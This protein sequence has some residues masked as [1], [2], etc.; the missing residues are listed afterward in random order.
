MSYL[1]LARAWRPQTFDEAVG[2]QHV[3][4]TLKNA[5]R[6]G[7]VAHAYLFSGPRG[8]GKTSLARILAKAVNCEQ[9]PTPDPCGTCTHCVEIRE[10]SAI[11]VQEI[12]GASNRGIEEIRELRENARYLP[13]GSRYKIYI[14]DEVHMLTKEAFNALLKT[15]EE[16]PRHVLFVF[17]TTEAHRVPATIVSRCQKF[18]FRRVPVRELETHLRRIVEHEDVEVDPGGLAILARQADGSVRDALSLLDQVISYGDRKVGVAMVRDILGLVDREFVLSLIENLVFK[19]IVPVLEALENVY[20]GGYDLKQFHHSLL[21]EIRSLML[22]KIGAGGNPEEDPGSEEPLR[23]IL[24]EV[25]VP[26]LQAAQYELLKLD[27][28]LRYASIPRLTLELGLLRLAHLNDF[29]GLSFLLPPEPSRDADPTG[30]TADT[31][32]SPERPRAGYHE[33][34]EANPPLE[35][36]S[37]EFSQAEAAT[38]PAPEPQAPE[39]GSTREDDPEDP[40]DAAAFVEAVAAHKP[41]LAPILRNARIFLEEKD[42]LVV[43]LPSRPAFNVSVIRDAR[44]ELSDLAARRLGP[45]CRLRIVE[46]ETPETSAPGSQESLDEQRKHM[47]KQALMHPMVREIQKVFQGELVGY[48]PPEAPQHKERFD[49]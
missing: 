6:Q 19:K 43:E 36:R 26:W 49:G 37:R 10:G 15:L 29:Y 1:V 48:Q 47:Q 45:A 20:S 31:H 41:S 32:P 2:Q 8:V 39:C 33:I 25:S 34:R 28:E 13:S 9:G 23:R 17:A 21:W 38:P 11:D 3:T 7:R 42:R 4:R 5:I 27:G 30:R 16:P 18:L 40:F 12:D 46:T 24:A 14:I 44:G 35:P 22:R